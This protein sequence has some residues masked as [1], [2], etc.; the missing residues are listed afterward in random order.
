MYDAERLLRIIGDIEKYLRDLNDMK[1]KSAASLNKEQFYSLSMILF[2]MLNRAIDLGEE[3]VRGKQLG[4]PMSYKEIFQML[5]KERVIS[6]ALAEELSG[7]VSLRNVLAHEYY[8]VT[9]KS[10]F[11]AYK[12]AGAIVDFVKIAK[13]LISADKK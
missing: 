8:D 2:A 7:L 10:I 11:E 5:G 1:I 3:I 6:P 13:K 9:S 12:Q 4:T